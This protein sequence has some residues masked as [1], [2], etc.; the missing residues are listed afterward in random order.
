MNGLDSIFPKERILTDESSLSE[1]AHDWAKNIDFKASAVVFPKT[2]KEVQDLVH[3]ARK[4]SMALIPSGGR[5]GLSGGAT[6]TQGEVI[7][8]FQK[9]NQILQFNEVDSSVWVEPGVVTEDLQNFAKEKALSFPVDFAARGSSQ[10]GGNVATNAGGINVVRYGLMRDWVLSLEVVTGTGEVLKL[11]NGLV[12]N[13][14]GYDLRHLMIGSEGTLGFVTRIEIKL[15]S[16][17]QGSMVFLLAVDQLSAVMEI[18]K[19]FRSRL[20]LLAFEMFTHKA[21]EVVLKTQK[22][23]SPPFSESHPY[24][25]VIDCEKRDEVSEETALEIF[26]FC[27][28]QGWVLDGVLAQSATQAKEIWRY[29][30]DISESTAA[31][32]PYKNDI[33]VRISHVPEFLMSTEKLLTQEYPELEVVWFGHIGDGNLHINVLKPQAWSKKDF[34]EKCDHVNQLLF[35]NLQKFEGSV[36]AEHGVGL[37]KKPYLH[38]TRSEYELEIFRG[39]KKVFDPDGILNPGKIF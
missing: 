17:P 34:L 35:R 24:Y 22:S 1:Y 32:S 12:K 39:I 28:E 19:K 16:P 20:S 5:T 7:V 27:A 37:V 18:F 38:F 14:S 13:A 25:L 26:E 2:T 15:C 9:M 23:M 3:W 10:I 33:S 6:A 21:L 11:N 36:S 8:S 31:Y 4:N 30:E 29:R